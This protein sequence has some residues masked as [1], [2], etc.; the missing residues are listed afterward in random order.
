M[1]NFYFSLPRP[2]P[3]YFVMDYNNLASSIR[4]LT[5]SL[6]YWSSTV[7]I[8]TSESGKLLDISSAAKGKSSLI[9]LSA[10]NQP[11]KYPTAK[12]GSFYMFDPALYHGPDSWEDLKPCCVRQVVSVAAKF[13]LLGIPGRG[14]PPERNLTHWL[15]SSSVPM[16]HGPPLPLH[17]VLLVLTM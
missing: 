10:T 14:L 15:V 4:D 13:Q 3:P 8:P 16:N 17:L 12:N 5:R 7:C 9:P 6:T 2:F 1:H 11:T